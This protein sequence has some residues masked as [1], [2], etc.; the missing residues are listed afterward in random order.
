MNGHLIRDPSSHRY[1]TQI[2]NMVIEKRELSH[3]AMR[4][5]LWF[6]KVCGEG[7]GECY[8]SLTT[9][10]EGCSMR[11]QTVV[12]ARRE[13]EHHKLVETERTVNKNGSS[14]IL[15]TIVDIWKQNIS[16][17]DTVTKS[18]IG[19]SEKVTG[20]VR[21]GDGNKNP[22]NKKDSMSA[23]KDA[24]GE[25]LRLERRKK[26]TPSSFDH[27]AVK[28]LRK[29]ISKHVKP[30]C[31]ADMKDWANQIRLMRQKDEVPKEEIQRII[32]WYD[33]HIGEEYMVEFFSASA[34]REKY[35]SGK[36]TSAMNKTNGQSL[37]SPTAAK[38]G[39]EMEGMIYAVQEALAAKGMDT[40]NTPIMQEDVD[41]VLQEMGMEPGIVDANVV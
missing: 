39:R 21:N 32:K 31:K 14:Q 38:A 15:V 3:A 10:S 11:R 22:V 28:E 20:A 8:Q 34:L 12:D 37:P 13:L 19:G 29:V 16:Q 5:Y 4:L 18:P 7:E 25:C 35:K 36:I 27:R 17:Y 26:R 33:N 9:L 6:K 30:N 23:S 2:P 1:Y 41:G 24:D 40:M